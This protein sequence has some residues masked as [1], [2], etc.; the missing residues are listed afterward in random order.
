VRPLTFEE[1]YPS[2]TK[3][4]Q[5]V[6]HEET[7]EVL[8]VPFRRIKLSDPDPGCGHLDLYDTR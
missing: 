6:T 1:A 5:V 2:S 7:G 8:K 3:E 4:Y